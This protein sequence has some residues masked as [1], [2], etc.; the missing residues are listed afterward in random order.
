MTRNWFGST[1]RIGV[2]LAL[3]LAVAAP[4]YAQLGSMKGKVVDEAGNPVPDADITFEYM[5]EMSY[6]FTAKSDA[7][8][9]FIRAGLYAVGG[10]WNVSATKGNLGGFVDNVEVQQGAFSEA[11]DIV[12]RPGG[13]RPQGGG[14]GDAQAEERNRQLA[15]VRALFDEVNAAL[16]ANAYD[17]AIAKLTEATTQVEGCAICYTRLGD[18]YFKQ[19][20]MEQAEASFRKSI[21]LDAAAPDAYDGLAILYNSQ[22][23]FAEAGEASAKASELRGAGGMAGDATSLFNAGAIFVNQGKMVE[24]QAEFEK[25]IAI[26]PT[27]AEAHYQLAMTLLNQ[28]KVAEA[29]KSLE[30]Y[31]SLGPTGPNAQ[32]AQD[33]LPELKTMQ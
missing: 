4:A 20:E 8:G 3:C 22:K 21:E 27:M 11:P 32:A 7:N 25:A 23:R 30:Q 31:L 13:S 5:G 28:G 6:R 1:L 29:I 15:A 19:G 2:L 18:V 14:M 16:A 33:M 17:V 26:D 9:E 12:M 10:N 24:A